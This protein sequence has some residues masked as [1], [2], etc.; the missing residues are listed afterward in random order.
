MNINFSWN[1]DTPCCDSDSL[2]QDGISLLDCLLTDDGGSGIEQSLA[3]I[4]EGIRRVQAVESGELESSDWNRETWGVVLGKHLARIYSLHDE[5]YFQ[6]VSIEG[7]LK[8]L[9]AW[10]GFV[11]THRSERVKIEFSIAG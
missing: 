2:N 1:G 6:T 5:E 8:V 7:F 4:D 10:S 3:W 11:Q 9:Q